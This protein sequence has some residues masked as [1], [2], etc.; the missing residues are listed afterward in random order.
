M[1]KRVVI[2]K[3]GGPAVLEVIADAVEAPAAHEVGVRVQAAGVSYAEILQ[4]EGLYPDPPKL[5]YTPGYDI[6]GIVEQTGTQVHDFEVGQKVAALVKFGGYTEYIN[7]AADK[8]VP[9]PQELDSAEVS[10]LVL[11]YLTAYQLLHRMANVEQGSRVLIHAAAGGVGTALGQ[12]GQ[13][14]G[15]EMYGTVSGGKQ[16]TVQAY[17]ATPINYKQQDFVQRIA[18]LTPDGVD[19]VFDAIGGSHW[20]RSYATLRPGG[21]LIAY[22]FQTAISDGRRNILKT[23]A[24]FLRMPRYTPLSLLGGSNAIMGFDINNRPD[25]IRADLRILVELL[26]QRKI[27]P[28]VAERLPLEQ[29]ERAHELLGAG[30]ATGKLVLVMNHA[31]MA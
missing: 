4:R 19:A 6:V 3:H 14:A 2:T 11:N 12:L 10:T 16:A 20:K 5:P 28:L 29:V 18:E 26:A 1:Y 17:G 23:I 9:V 7:V 30:A 15:L 21:R 8:L 22:G 25:W 27:N 31:D 24:G 13:L